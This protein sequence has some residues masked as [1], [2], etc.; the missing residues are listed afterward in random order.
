MRT[1]AD[2]DAQTE[3]EPAGAVA[4]RVVLSYPAAL[5]ERTRERVG[6]RYYRTYLAR[7]HDSAEVGAE[8]EEF[9]DVGCCGS[10]IHVPFRVERV[11][12]GSQVA[13]DTEIEFTVREEGEIKGG[14]AVQN[15]LDGRGE[16]RA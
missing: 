2:A 11:D 4:E 6:Q 13:A 12:G 8:W 7:A 15:E 14:W 1:D 9:T 3:D 5:S 10:Q 16:E